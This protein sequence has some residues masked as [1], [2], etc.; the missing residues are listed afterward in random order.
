MLYFGSD[1]TCS[2][3]NSNTLPPMVNETL[4]IS[5][6]KYCIQQLILHLDWE[7]YHRAINA[8]EI[9]TYEIL[10]T[11]TNYVFYKLY[12]AEWFTELA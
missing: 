12:C 4:G 9:T 10:K 11:D 2:G 5:V 7:A 3:E 1:Y 6:V 8:T